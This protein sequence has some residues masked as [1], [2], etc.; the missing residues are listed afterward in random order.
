MKKMNAAS[1]RLLARLCARTS[2]VAR[3]IYVA[4]AHHRNDARHA[5][6]HHFCMYP[7]PVSRHDIPFFSSTAPEPVHHS[8]NALNGALCWW[9]SSSSFR[10]GYRSTIMN[11]SAA[12]SEAHSSSARG[13]RQGTKEARV[14][15]RQ[16]K[17]KRRASR[18]GGDG[19]TSNTCR[20]RRTAQR[21]R[22]VVL[23]VLREDAEAPL[24]LV[25]HIR[26]DLDANVK[27]EDVH[28]APRVRRASALRARNRYDFTYECEKFVSRAL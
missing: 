8:L 10:E 13:S 22:L 14:T 6:R 1:K 16:W 2:P 4:Y 12:W 27:A 23:D 3:Y 24:E 15:G 9:G 20:W 25:H 5:N 7:T 28:G 11:S 26:L 19:K 18:A 17:E 21:E